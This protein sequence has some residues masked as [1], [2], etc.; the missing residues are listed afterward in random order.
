MQHARVCRLQVPLPPTLMDESG[1]E[2]TWGDVIGAHSQ[3]LRFGSTRPRPAEQIPGCSGR[4]GADGKNVGEVPEM[5]WISSMDSPYDSVY[6][7][8]AVP[9]I[10]TSRH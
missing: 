3:Y 10:I 1:R 5:P 4:K 9:F 2:R 8:W 6:L 7:D